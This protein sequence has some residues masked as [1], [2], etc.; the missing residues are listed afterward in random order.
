MS[1]QSKRT[2]SA[3][4]A[5]LLRRIPSVDELLAQ[6]RLASLAKRVDRNL[7]VDVTRAALTDLRSKITGESSIALAALDPAS[8]QEHISGLVEQILSRS[9]QSVINATGVILHTNLGRAPLTAAAV[10][11]FRRTATQYS[12]LEY[13][14]EAGARGKRDV[15]TAQLLERLTGAEA[16][17][18]VNNCAAAVLLVLAALAKGGEAIVSRGELIEIGDGF[19]IPE[20][21]A[22]SGAVLREVGTTNRTRVA[23]YENAINENTRLLLRVHPSN[24]TITGFAEKPTLE[25][26]VA[27]SRRS[28]LPLVE[29]LGSG[30][31]VDLSEAGITEPVVRQSIDSGVSLVMFSGDKLLGGPQA[32]IIAGNKELVSRVRR[33]PLFRALRVDKLTIAA[34]E[35]T[36][37][38]YLRGAVDEIP[39]LRMIRLTVEE[40][41][42]RAENFLRELTPELP[43]GEVELEIADGASLAGGGSTPAQSLPSKIIRIASARY[44]AAQLEQRLRRA[45]AGVSVIARVEDDRLVLDLRTVFPEQELLLL[46]TLAAALH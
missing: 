4:Q 32:G 42:R 21:M 35:A 17:I 23:D 2:L 46:K 31:L 33:H 5:D 40:L 41:Q 44:S 19:R 36:L 13:D 22:E 9:L 11:E 15:H 1:S 38:A 28:G 18:V 34:L 29:D 10:E 6:P 7:L 26:L 24:F 45:P 27:L 3:D 14:L 8:L 20:I 37:G 25:E 39:T 12:N 16:A 43:L 30:C